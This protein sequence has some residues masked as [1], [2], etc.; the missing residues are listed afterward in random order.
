MNEKVLYQSLLAGIY[1]GQFNPDKDPEDLVVEAL[2]VIANGY[3]KGK[4]D[5]SALVGENG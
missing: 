5:I 1:I 4:I 3:S 2:K